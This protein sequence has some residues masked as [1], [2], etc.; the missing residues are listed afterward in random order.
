MSMVVTCK[1]GKRL[2]AQDSH[3]GKRVRCSHCSQV[4]VLPTLPD[5]PPVVTLDDEAAMYYLIEDCQAQ[6]PFTR[7]DL[8][9]RRLGASS[10]VWRAG[11]SDWHRAD[12]L[13][14][15]Q[16]V[17]TK[18]PPPVPLNAGSHPGR[19]HEPSRLYDPKAFETLY[20]W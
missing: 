19:S 20:S 14:E 11:L 2:R 7:I 5:I 4:L 18:S 9:S 1:C 6:G 3:A 12:Q 13:T 17:L 16:P 10:L 8:K 15:L